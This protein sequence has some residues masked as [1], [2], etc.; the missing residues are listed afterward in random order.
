V[1]IL[2]A[3]ALV[4]IAESGQAGNSRLYAS[5]R[6]DKRWSSLSIAAAFVKSSFE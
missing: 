1:D 3:N 6:K 2:G 5:P 4:K